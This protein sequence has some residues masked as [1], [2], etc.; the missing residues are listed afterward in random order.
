MRTQKQF[1]LRI[2][3][4]FL[5][6]SGNFYFSSHYFC[7]RLFASDFNT[8]TNPVSLFDESYFPYADYQKL[9]RL[10]EQDSCADWA[11]RAA[12]Q[13]ISFFEHI[14]NSEQDLRTDLSALADLLLLAPESE[15]VSLN[16]SEEPFTAQ[17]I[18]KSLQ[19]RLPLWSQVVTALEQEP[20]LEESE[21]YGVTPFK[22]VSDAIR[23]YKKSN[24]IRT[25]L[26][27]NQNGQHW[28]QFFQLNPLHE[29]LTYLI[30]N[31]EQAVM[32]VTAQSAEPTEKYASQYIISSDEAEPNQSPVNFLNVSDVSL[33]E[34]ECRKICSTVNYFFMTK[35]RVS[36]K[37]EQSQLLEIPAIQDWLMEMEQWQG[38]PIHPL[39]LLS[40]YEEYRFYHGMSDSSRLALLSRQLLGSKSKALQ[41]LGQAVQNEFT[42]AHLKVYVSRYL[43]NTMLPPR[44]P[45][46]DVVRETIAGQE[47]VGKRRADTQVNISLIPDPNRLLMSLN[48]N[49]QVITQTTASTFPA[50]LHNQSHGTYSASKQLE[51][52]TK[53]VQVS[54]AKVIANSKVKLKE[55][56]T[57]LDILPIVGDL[58]RE[59]AKGQY[60]NQQSQIQA[61]A[62][63]KMMMQAKQRV[64]SEADERFKIFNERLERLFL[65]VIRQQNASLEL[66]EA[67][68]T[69][70]WLL[71]SW[72]LSTP[73]SLGSDSK[74]PATPEGSIA[75]LK[76]HELGLNAALER[77]NLAGKQMTIAELRRYLTNVIQRPDLDMTA[78]DEDDVVVGFA[79][80]NP[81][82]IRFLKNRVELSLNLSHLLVDDKEWNDFCVLVNYIPD[83]D[84]NGSPCL[85]RDGVVQLIGDLNLSQQVVLRAIFSKIFHNRQPISLKPKLFREDERFAGLNTG[86]VRIDNGWFAIALVPQQVSQIPQNQMPPK[87]TKS[88]WNRSIRQSAVVP[89]QKESVIMSAIRQDDTIVR[90]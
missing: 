82:G 44:D 58:V 72:Y 35:N 50:T 45:E 61:D 65:S 30:P 67:K 33:D 34:A 79:N 24:A 54:P 17:S 27:L 87:I 57:D 11:K 9:E 42:H 70:E 66:H 37:P 69:E 59:I 5:I 60:Q 80:I 20:I 39:E 83:I 84:A 1:I 12:K 10:Q 81:L 74:D 14:Q 86:F 13:L 19:I 43:I 2:L 77:L 31:Q 55:V 85:V 90:R 46:F 63:S 41:E 22:R 52:T 48:I 15:V 78:A 51:L 21:K 62:K 73:V 38:N 25:T 47:V 7:E 28:I 16:E 23:L 68:T 29:Q 88:Q 3:P 8:S 56:Q 26:L 64:D 4:C 76:V 18:A 89:A 49:G 36:M 71:T 40:V 6:F 53:G 32:A 75:D